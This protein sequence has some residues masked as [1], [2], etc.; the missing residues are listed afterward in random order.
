M[1]IT[2]KLHNI[3]K[4]KTYLKKHN[5]F[6][7]FNGINTNSLDWLIVEQNLKL[8]KF[9]YRKII[10]KNV[11]KSLEK[12]IYN[13]LSFALTGVLFFVEP[14]NNVKFLSKKILS[15]KFESLFF[16]LLVVKLNNKLYSAKTLKNMNFL[17]Y[18]DNNLL[19]FQSLVVNLKFC[20]Q[21]L[22]KSK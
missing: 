10:N 21:K 8:T 12:S 11:S 6:F 2:S 19:L 22:K 13:N 17:N 16:T 14:N 4:T 15:N 1:E 5:L 20:S 18:K 9:N 7:L 3:A